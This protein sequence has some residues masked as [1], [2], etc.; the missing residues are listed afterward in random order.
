MPPN[1]VHFNQL[2]WTSYYASADA[3]QQ[4]FQISYKPIGL[5][6]SIHIRLGGHSTFILVHARPEGPYRGA[7]EPGCERTTAEV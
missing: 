3:C 4:R 7:C 1:L 5:V 2:D 6:S